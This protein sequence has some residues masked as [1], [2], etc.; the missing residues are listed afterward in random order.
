MACSDQLPVAFIVAAC[1][2][3]KQGRANMAALDGPHTK[4]KDSGLDPLARTK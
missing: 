4:A 1:Q 3:S 2:A